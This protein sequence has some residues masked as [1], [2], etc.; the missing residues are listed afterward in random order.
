MDTVLKLNMS[1]FISDRYSPPLHLCLCQ[2]KVISSVQK[3]RRPSD[4]FRPDQFTSPITTLTSTPVPQRAQSVS[5]SESPQGKLVIMVE[6]FY[7]GSAPG[8]S[9]TKMNL[10]G[11]KFSGPYRCIHCP[12]TLMSHMKQHVDIMSKEEGGRDSSSYCPHCFRHFSS[13]L[14]LQ[15]HM[16]AVHSLVFAAKCLICE[17]EFGNEATFLMHMK[18]THKPGEMPY[19]CQVCEFRSSSYSDVW[20]HFEEAHADTKHL[21]CQYCLR[22]QCSSTY[23]QQHFI[24]HLKNQVFDCEKCRLQFLY[25]KERIEHKML[26]HKTHIKPLQLRGLKPGTR[27]TVRTYSVVQQLD[28]EEQSKEAVAPCKVST[29]LNL[30]KLNLKHIVPSVFLLFVTSLFVFCSEAVYPSCPSQ[31]CIECM[32]MVQDFSSHFPSMVKCSLC[33][34]ITCCS[35]SYANHMI[36]LDH[37][38]TCVS[39]SFSTT[40]GDVMANHLTEQPQHHCVMPT[41]RSKLC[42]HLCYS[43]RLP[44]P[45]SPYV[46]SANQLSAVLFSLCNGLSQAARHFNMSPALIDAW[47]RQQEHQLADK[48]WK[49][50]TS[51]VAKWVLTQREQQRGLSE[52]TLLQTAKRALGEYSPLISQYQWAIDFMLRHDLSVQITNGKDRRRRQPKDLADLCRSIIITVSQ[53]NQFLEKQDTTR[54]TRRCLPPRSFGCMDELAIYM[55]SDSLSSQNPEALRLTASAE[56]TPMFDILLSALS[57]GTMLSPLLFYRGTPVDIPE[58]FPQNVLVKAQKDGFTDPDR[59]HTWINKVWC[60]HV[61]SPPHHECLLLLDVHR[62][63]LTDEIRNSLKRAHTQAIFIPAGCCCRLQPLDVCVIPVLK[64]FLQVLT[65]LCLSF[66]SVCSLQQ[67]GNEEVE[68][69]IKGLTEALIQPL[70]VSE[71]P[72]PPDPS[73]LRQVFEGDSDPESFLG[74]EDTEADE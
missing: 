17:L 19:I 63:H 60:P 69:L 61:T 70:E 14:R 39:C 41:N 1:L 16:E 10:V 18:N 43:A 73:A 62:G 28:S 54:S 9:T 26:H 55:D 65:H 23:Y 42:K 36:K 2:N 56:E 8:H 25:V 72:P 37:R 5:A 38:L 32:V 7:Y 35:T 67:S 33:R 12:L 52:E 44:P 71:G 58:G 48:I 50:K 34:F 15:S 4:D 24:K 13:P 64:E 29:N 53:Q 11:R 22:V 51:H 45:P 74:F 30:N 47:T 20:S 3:P 49:W 6:D 31:L 57:D 21:M 68:R 66:L 27:V 59:L 46:L 40:R